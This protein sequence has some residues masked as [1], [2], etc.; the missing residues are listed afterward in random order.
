MIFVSRFRG[1][2]NYYTNAKR[3]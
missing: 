2:E 1:K 3:R